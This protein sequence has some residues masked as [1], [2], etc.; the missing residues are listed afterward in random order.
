M[1]KA[2]EYKALFLLA[3]NGWRRWL[4]HQTFILFNA[5]EVWQERWPEWMKIRTEWEGRLWFWL[6]TKGFR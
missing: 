1:K 5:F 3:A 6:A 4:W 2:A